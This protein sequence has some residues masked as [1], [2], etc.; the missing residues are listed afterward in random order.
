[1]VAL[2]AAGGV[3]ALGALLWFTAVGQAKPTATASRRRS[4]MRRKPRQRP[5]T[6]SPQAAAPGS[7]VSIKV[8]ATLTSG[9]AW[10]STSYAFG[11]GSRDVRE[12]ARPTPR[13][14]HEYVDVTLP[15]TTPDAGLGDGATL[16]RGR[17]LT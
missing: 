7:F 6:G 14:A 15:E 13:P 17:L 8:T 3:L 4:W 5:S 2:P 11:S 1:M 10:R 9:E 16:L 12:H